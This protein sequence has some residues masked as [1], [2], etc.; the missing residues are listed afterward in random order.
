MEYIHH[1]DSE[2]RT[3][4]V[5]TPCLLRACAGMPVHGCHSIQLHV[6]TVTDTDTLQPGQ[7][8]KKSTYLQSFS[9]HVIAF[10]PQSVILANSKGA[11]VFADL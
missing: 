5:K 4:L 11:T 8:V 9:F 7:T 6:H 3:L 2:M 10:P 1:P